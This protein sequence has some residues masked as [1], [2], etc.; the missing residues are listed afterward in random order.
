MA[1]YSR[2]D[3]TEIKTWT[4]AVFE[5]LGAPADDAFALVPGLP[6]TVTVS[7]PEIRRAIE[8]QLHAIVDAVRHFGVN[9]ILMPC[10]PER[11]WKAI[12]TSIPKGGA[13]E[14]AAMPHFD[15]DEPGASTGSTTD[16]E[17]AGL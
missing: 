6:R 15:T 7:S 13:T 11:V 2:F 5:K 12:T 8:E 1:D 16:A 14:A 3:A 10:T 17:G 4:S 9:D